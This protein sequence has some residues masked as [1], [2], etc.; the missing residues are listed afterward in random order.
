MTRKTKRKTKTMRK[1]RKMKTVRRGNQKGTGNEQEN[2][3]E[4]AKTMKTP[5]FV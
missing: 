2:D 1:Q 5:D 4:D 3:A